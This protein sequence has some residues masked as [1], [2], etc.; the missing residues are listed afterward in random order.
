MLKIRK[1]LY[2]TFYISKPDNDINPFKDYYPGCSRELFKSLNEKCS[3]CYNPLYNKKSTPDS[4]KHV[5]CYICLSKWEK[6]S[7]VCPICRRLF[8]N[9]IYY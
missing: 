4:C 1:S 2:S 3:I 9:I 5:F 6:I 7:K 8:R